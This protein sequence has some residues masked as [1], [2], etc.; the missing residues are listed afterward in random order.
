MRYKAGGYRAVDGKWS[1]SYLRS[2]NDESGLLRSPFRQEELSAQERDKKIAAAQLLK[3]ALSP[4]LRNLKILMSEKCFDP[5]LCQCQFRLRP[6]FAIDMG[7]ASC[8]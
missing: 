8:R 3:Y 4:L 7:R 1:N 2:G 6:V 5:D